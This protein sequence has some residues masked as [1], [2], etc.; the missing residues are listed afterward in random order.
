MFTQTT[1]S[2]A[3][4]EPAAPPSP[5]AAR[6]GALSVAGVLAV[7]FAP[8]LLGPDEFQYRDT[9]RM[10][11]PVKRWVADE[12]AHG[13][14]PQW[15]PYSGLGSP[16]VAAATDAVQ[17]P[18]NLA[19]LVLPPGAAMK[20]W[21]LLSYALAAAG[22]FAWARALGRGEAGCAVA[23]LAFA[24][25]GPLVSSSD[26]VTYL[27]TYATLPWMFA[28]AHVHA[29]RG[30]PLRLALVAFASAATAAAGD[31]QAWAIAV[32]LLPGYSA[33]SADRGSRGRAFLGGVLAAGAAAVAAAPFVLPMLAWLPH[34][35]RAAGI[36]ADDAARWNLHPRRLLELIVPE[37]FRGT[38]DDPLSPVFAAYAGNALTP[39]P[40]FLSLYAGAGVAAL[41]LLGAFRDRRARLLLLAAAGFAWAALGPHAGFGAI[42]ARLP[43]VGAFRYWEKLS[44]WIPLLVAVPAALGAEALL[45][46]WGARR[47]SRAAATAAAALLAAAAFAALAPG[48]LAALAGGPRAAGLGLAANLASG[49]ARAGLVLALLAT[50]AAA[51]DRR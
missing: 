43:I 7:F 47:F 9:G 21:I 41:A 27:T 3:P 26:N 19:L 17:H 51:L 35:G 23:A 38:P 11:A 50:T 16:V 44:V 37:L 8:A 31:P 32:A 1:P 5:R 29:R 18:F 33:A 36:S 42:A 25:S 14:L 45:A 39:L 49:A 22:A 12:L 2:P 28:A 48:A 15:N 34:T 20:A 46:G 4:P 30:G 6:L 40:W 10:H 13:R 24:L